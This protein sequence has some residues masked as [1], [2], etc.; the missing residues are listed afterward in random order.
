MTLLTKFT[1]AVAG[2]PGSSSAKTW[3][4]LSD[5]WA[6]FLDTNPKHRLEWK[7][8]KNENTRRFLIS[9]GETHLKIHW[10]QQ[11]SLCTKRSSGIVA[12]KVPGSFLRVQAAV[13]NIVRW[14]MPPEEE[15]AGIV[16][17]RNALSGN[18]EVNDRRCRQRFLVEE[19]RYSFLNSL[20]SG[21][22]LGVDRKEV[23]NVAGCQMEF[24]QLFFL[25][26]MVFA[27]SQFLFS[28]YTHAIVKKYNGAGQCRKFWV[29]D[30][31]NGHS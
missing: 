9:S 24:V 21:Q 30:C 31:R 8:K 18:L 1:I 16:G 28:Y 17:Q 6:G 7:K 29:L 23:Q 26:S 2:C 12:D 3:H 4:W 13:A 14:I 10:Q 27:K 25:I 11:N 15:L 20:R 22:R 19:R 5:L